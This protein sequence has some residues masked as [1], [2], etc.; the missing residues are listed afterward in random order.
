[1]TRAMVRLHVASA[2]NEVMVHIADLLAEGLATNGVGSE[3]VVD[4]LPLE[5]RHVGALSVVVAPHEFFPLHF[6]RTR[7]TIELEPTLASV[8]VLNVEQ[9][10]SQWFDVGWEFARRARHV[11]DISPAGVAEFHRRGV[12]AV[13]T[14]L[15]YLPSL[16]APALQPASDRAIDVLFL[17]HASERRNAFFA[18]HAD[19]FSTFNCHLVVSE[20]NRPRLAATPGYRSGDQRLALIASSRILLCVHSTERPYFE[21]HRAMLALA[22]GCLLVTESSQHTEPLQDGVHFASAATRRAAG[23]LPPLSDRPVRA[24]EGRDG[25]PRDGDRPYAPPPEQRDPARRDAAASRLDVQRRG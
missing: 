9:P 24:R 8:A 2:G 21:Q 5:D 4:G 19:F 12:T 6:L 22:N 10:G 11:F 3:V 1:M 15:G 17:G 18:R 23:S 20:V 25:R 14:P 16:E 13:H 7:P